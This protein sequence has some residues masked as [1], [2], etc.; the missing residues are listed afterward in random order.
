MNIEQQI[1]NALLNNANG[2]QAKILGLTQPTLIAMKRGKS[3]TSFSKLFDVLFENGIKTISLRS[4]HT[5]MDFDCQN[6]EVTVT[7]KSVSNE[8]P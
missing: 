7:T 4:E 2:N 1:Y 5:I 3:R 6:K 8:N